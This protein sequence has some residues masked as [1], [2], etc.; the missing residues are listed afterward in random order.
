MPNILEELEEDLRKAFDEV[1]PGSEAITV[2]R[3]KIQEI[4]Q[5]LLRMGWDK[6]RLGRRSS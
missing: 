3:E 1:D 2:K 4:A 6:R 5:L